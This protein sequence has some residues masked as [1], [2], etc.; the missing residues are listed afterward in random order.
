MFYFKGIKKCKF[1]YSFPPFE[2][3]RLSNFSLGNKKSCRTLNARC[4]EL[5][6]S[7]N[8][9]ESENAN[10]MS[11][12][13][14]FCICFFVIIAYGCRSI[15]ATVP[16]LENVELKPFTPKESV[17]NIDLQ[18]SLIP[19]FKMVE[20]NT[21]KEFSG[22]E[23]SCEGISYAYHFRRDPFEFKTSPKEVLYTLNGDFSL[24]LN[25]CPLCVTMLGKSSCT[26]P[27]IYGS[28][29]IDEPRI[30]YTMT[31]GTRIKLN[32][33]YT[34]SSTTK[35]KNFKIKNPCEITFIN[36]DVTSE[37]KE[38]METELRAMEEKIDKEISQIN[39]KNKVDSLWRE[40]NK[41]VKIGS[42][43]Q[44]NINPKRITISDVQYHERM[45]NVSLNLFFAPFVSTQDEVSANVNL[46]DMST[47]QEINGFDITADFKASFDSL[48]AILRKELYN[49]EIQIKGKDFVIKDITIVG[50]KYSKLVFKLVF[51]GHRNGT[52][53]LIATPFLDKKNQLLRFD[54]IDFELETKSLLLKSAEWLMSKKVINTLKEKS[55]IN[56]SKHLTA[57]KSNIKKKLNNEIVSGI[58]AETSISDLRI[59]NLL[60]SSKHIAIRTS[61]TGNLKIRID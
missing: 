36:Y 24:E 48:S 27:R 30:R 47:H 19:I 50:V 13:F 26:I 53:Y 18:A 52:F 11:Y 40:L 7:I 8:L 54:D 16:K 14:F 34:L 37:V 31:Y 32:K 45:A 12:K 44:L 23:Q 55:T 10:Y 21:P 60:L 42:Y 20:S 33:N 5:K 6:K 2:C 46:E 1:S 35:L 57:I 4:L 41:P 56:L 39:L 9:A 59:E 38:E 25:Y 43:G 29:G 17:M 3:N 22:A 58:H 61:I 28:C 51:E 49:Y 15:E